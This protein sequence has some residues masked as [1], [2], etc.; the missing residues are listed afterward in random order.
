MIGR[1]VEI[2]ILFF[3]YKEYRDVLELD[4]DKSFIQC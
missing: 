3:S 2:S 1:Y 4:T